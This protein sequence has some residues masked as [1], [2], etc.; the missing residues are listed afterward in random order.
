MEGG[1]LF[2]VFFLLRPHFR[3]FWATAVRKAIATVSFRDKF[4]RKKTIQ[5]VPERVSGVNIGDPLP[6]PESR[7]EDPLTC[8]LVHAVL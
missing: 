3:L 6:R 5:P 4:D 2:L 8:S 1:F 7:Q